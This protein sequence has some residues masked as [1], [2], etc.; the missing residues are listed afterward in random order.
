MGL[1][2]AILG[3]FGP[4][5]AIFGPF[6]AILGP[7]LGP[8]RAILGHFGAILGHLGP[9]WGHFGAFLA[10]TLAR[11]LTLKRGKKRP[12]GSTLRGQ[13]PWV[14]AQGATQGRPKKGG[15]K[16][17]LGC[18]RRFFRAHGAPFWENVEESCIKN[19][20]LQ[21][22]KLPSPKLQSIGLQILREHFII[23]VRLLNTR[24]CSSGRRALFYPMCSA[25]VGR[26]YDR[27]NL[28]FR[29][30]TSVYIHVLSRVCTSARGP[31]R[32]NSWGRG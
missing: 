10:R 8:F 26:A 24:V 5:L 30:L 19:N 7:F 29:K 31:L 9:F 6:G 11:K 2:L 17:F 25:Q 12:L 21:S 22:N 18:E 27:Q 15:H 14:S 13:H 32:K 4:F 3:H 1:F 28:F 20:A 23:L 16:F